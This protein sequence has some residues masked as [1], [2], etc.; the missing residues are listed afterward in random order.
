MAKKDNIKDIFFEDETKPINKEQ[1][2]LSNN[3]D[4]KYGEYYQKNVVYK[5]KDGINTTVIYN[6]KEHIYCERNMR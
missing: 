2:S 5:Y 3:K 6:A 4:N 1:P